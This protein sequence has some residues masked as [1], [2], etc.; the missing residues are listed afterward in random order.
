ML[1]KDK[2]VLITGATKGIGFATA[3][4]FAKEGAQLFINGRD[5]NALDLVV[6][7]LALTSIHKIN[8]LCFD[9][10]DSEQVEDGF[11][12]LFK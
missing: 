8:T 4:L 5:Q 1:V 10:S 6:E 12:K 2:I 9:V 7:E 3:K 11:Q